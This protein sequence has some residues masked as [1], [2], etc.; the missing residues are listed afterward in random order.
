MELSEEQFTD[1]VRQYKNPIYVPNNG[2][3]GDSLIAEGTFQFFKKHQIDYTIGSVNK[4]YTRNLVYAGG[5]NL[6]GYYHDCENW[7]KKNKNNKIL[8]LPHTVQNVDSLLRSLSKNV[9]IVCREQKSYEYVKSFNTVTTY[10]HKDM[11]F[12]INTDEYEI[13]G[14]G[15]G[16]FYR[17]DVEKTDIKIPSG[18]TDISAT[19]MTRGCTSSTSIVED[20]TRKFLDHINRYETINTNRLHVAIGGHLLGKK[21]NLHP[22]KYWKNEEIWKYN[23]KGV[24]NFIPD[25]K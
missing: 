13:G 19:Y 22:N 5:G 11:A 1:L 23:L 15:V 10:L 2:N 12:Y 17:T 3:A 18:N 7:I 14:S 16:N 25:N 4:N 21:V 20:T 9:T 24:V 6:V 8:I